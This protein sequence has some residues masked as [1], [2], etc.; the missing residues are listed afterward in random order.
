[1]RR[2]ITKIM[3][4]CMGIMMIF[5][6]S[7]CTRIT[8]ADRKDGFTTDYAMS[9]VE[10]TIFLSN[11]V[12]TIENILM[13]RISMYYTLADGKGMSSSYESEAKNAEEAILKLASIHTNIETTLP[14]SGY[15]SDRENFLRLTGE[16]EVVLNDYMK[17]LKGDG[18]LSAAG[19]AMKECYLSISGEANV[20][21][22]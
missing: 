2:F 8:R 4:F 21:Y 19:N 14:A 16:A 22:E 5:S 13:T 7:G 15:E 11:Q 12:A 17:A 18:S 1:M 10:Y 6:I 3:P 9:A 20:V